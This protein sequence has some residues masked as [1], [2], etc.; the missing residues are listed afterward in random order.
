MQEDYCGSGMSLSR[1]RSSIQCMLCSLSALA[2]ECG[3][4]N[5]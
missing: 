2:I 1:E 5:W 3:S 4:S